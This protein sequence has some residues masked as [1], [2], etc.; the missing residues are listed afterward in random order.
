MTYDL[1]DNTDKALK[2]YRKA[3]ELDPE[4]NDAREN[5]TAL[6]K[7]L[8]EEDEE[9]QAQSK[10]VEIKG[11]TSILEEVETPFFYSPELAQN[12]Y[13]RAVEHEEKDDIEKALEN[14]QKALQFDP[15]LDEAFENLSILEETLEDE[16]YETDFFNK[17]DLALDLFYENQKERSLAICNEIKG[18]LPPLSSAH[19]ELGLVFEE[20]EELEE[21]QILYQKA[22]QLNPR[23]I[24][25]F[26]NLRNINERL[27]ALIYELPS[28]DQNNL[29]EFVE[30][31][32]WNGLIEPLPGWVYNNANAYFLR[33]TPGHRT[34]P[35]KSGL[36]PV[37]SY[38]EDARVRGIIIRSLITFKLRTHNPVYLLSMAFFGTIMSLPFLYAIPALV[39]GDTG[40]LA[41]SM[42]NGV[43][44]P[45]LLVNVFLSLIT[46]RPEDIEDDG[47]P[48]F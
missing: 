23:L 21:A 16:F 48:F 31:G 42:L 33:G 2:N 7:E 24:A 46:K 12:Y 10:P 30:N 39:L 29:I 19:N 43:M 17:L 27:E 37:E 45:F 47:Y 14:Y 20:I 11:D 3:L 41:I 4:H 26:T 35:G 15:G 22:S 9:I 32:E 28:V 13:Q 36:D 25:A 40:L 6:K 5:L 44:G 8:G 18:G 1:W 34:L 38:A